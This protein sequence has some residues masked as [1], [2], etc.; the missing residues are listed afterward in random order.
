M[1]VL[2]APLNWGLGHAGRC[3]PL[4]RRHLQAGDEVVLAGDGESLLLLRRHFPNL[5][6]YRLA[7]LTIR[8]C[9]GNRQVWAMLRAIP[10]LLLFA[11]RDH[12]GLKQILRQESF[13]LIISDNRFGLFAKGHNCVY[14]THQLLIPLPR[15]YRW[16]E[17]LVARMHARLINRYAGC[18]VP[19][20]AEAPGLA[21]RLSHPER[22]PHRVQYIGP[23]SR[24]EQVQP[25]APSTPY[26]VVAVLSGPEPQRSM[27]EQQILEKYT[28]LTNTPP[29][30]LIV[31]GKMNG[32]N[33]T[34]R[35]GHITLV[36]Y[37][38]DAK[39]AGY[40]LQASVIISRS[41]YSSI[42]DYACLG[43]L[44]KQKRGEVCLRLVA[45]PGQPEQEY[46][47]SLLLS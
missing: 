22:L 44:D 19:D 31:R 32:P 25:L 16:L 47:N 5:R 27:L 40:L 18:Y 20:H 11:M 38:D 15:G 41:G 1:K 45:T 3:V 24:F 17:P 4:I 29:S 12:H 26:D 13:D 35:K 36:P 46:L 8:Y 34:I 30:V 21:G 37:L 28:S 6:C 10:R 43:L 23:L 33:T 39:L 7:P 42:M 9:K 14:M 2:I